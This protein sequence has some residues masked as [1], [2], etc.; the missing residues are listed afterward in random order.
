MDS[1]RDDILADR[2]DVEPPIFKGCSSTELVTML[3]AAVLIWVPLSIFIALLIG[4][5][6]Y[7]LGI[8]AVGI[9]GSVY[10]GAGAF[11]KV[12]RN[13]P[14]HYYVHAFLRF[15][16]LRKW[17]TSRFLWRSGYWDV[18]REIRSR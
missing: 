3:V 11:Q 13:R 1:D 9:I 15:L 5:L 12:K 14:D 8:T 4:K 7:A 17:R 2:V 18:G 10:F 16:H 6:P